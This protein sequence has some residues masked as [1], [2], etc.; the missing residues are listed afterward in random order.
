MKKFCCTI[1][2]ACLAVA[3]MADSKW[4]IS[5][6]VADIETKEPIPM[7][8]V[9]VMKADADSTYITGTATGE[10]GIFIIKPDKGG[11]MIVKIS[12][13]GYQPIQREVT[14]RRNQGVDLGDLLISPE[15]V[16]LKETVVTAQVPQVGSVFRN[17]NN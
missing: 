5:G 11:K 15:T 12:S 4:T 9:R 14:L 3:A 7:A 1:I 13:V 10:L 16:M 8:G 6:K 17:R 2:M